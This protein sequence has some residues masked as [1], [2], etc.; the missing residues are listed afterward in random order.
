MKI[1]KDYISM[2]PLE[3]ITDELYRMIFAKHFPGIDTFYTPFISPNQNGKYKPRDIRGVY[4]ENNQGL[5]LVPQILTNQPEHF[6]RTAKD[7][8]A[9]GYTEVNLNLGC[10]SGTVTAKRKGAGFLAYPE[11]LRTFLDAV[12]QQTDMAI[13]IK[14]RLGVKEK[15][16]FYMLLNIFQEF[17]I[18]ELIIHPRLQK[19]YYKGKPDKSMFAYAYETLEIPLTYNGNIFTA[20][21]FDEC[22]KDFPKLNSFMLGRGLIANP[23]L[24]EDI[25]HDIKARKMDAAEGKRQNGNGAERNKNQR[26]IEFHKEL[27]EGYVQLLSGEKNI[28]F[29]MKEVWQYMIYIFADS[30]RLGKQLRKT[31]SCRE[32]ESIVH[33]IC[34]QCRILEKD[35]YRLPF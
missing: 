7:M 6:V 29:H 12:F 5:H 26:I 8:K 31:S 18:K 10:P 16:E 20:K 32:Y 2:A 9:L 34:T 17:P 35:E 28:L 30:E 3:G 14:T 23:F 1:K 15:E 24:L 27:Y 21:E 13:S 22:K 11:E 19:D 33:T 4:P 25:K